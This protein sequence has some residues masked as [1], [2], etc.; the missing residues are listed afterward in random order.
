MLRRGGRQP[1]ARRIHILDPEQSVAKALINIYSYTCRNSYIYTY[2]LQVYIYIYSAAGHI[3]VPR[4][5]AAGHSYMYML[6]SAAGH[7]AV[8]RGRA[9]GRIYTYVY[10]YIYTYISTP[11]KPRKHK[12]KHP[13]HALTTT[14]ALKTKKNKTHIPPTLTHPFTGKHRANKKTEKNTNQ[15]SMLMPTVGRA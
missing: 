2:I 4:G 6:Y 10:I 12:K 14:K 9:A 13:P 8:P 7:I 3:T 11:T 1:R 15:V 5:R